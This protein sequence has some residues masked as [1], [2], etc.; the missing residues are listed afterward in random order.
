MFLVFSYSLA[1]PSLT[2]FSVQK[3]FSEITSW[4]VLISLHHVKTSLQ[5]GSEEDARP[6]I[7]AYEF[8]NLSICLS[9][10]MWKFKQNRHGWCDW[11][12]QI[13]AELPKLW[14]PSF[15]NWHM[16][17]L[18]GQH[19]V[20]PTQFSSSNLMYWLLETAVERCQYSDKVFPFT[21]V[22]W[23]IHNSRKDTF[24]FSN[25]KWL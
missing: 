20:P 9:A 4:E 7:H 17:F 22:H 24:L 12:S 2:Q 14:Q 16:W 6:C 13:V 11:S 5:G 18:L 25:S 10:R 8:S 19:G 1:C 21:F 15:S 23:E 3:L